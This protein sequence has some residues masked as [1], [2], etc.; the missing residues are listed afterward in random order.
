MPKTLLSFACVLGA[1][2]VMAL[3]WQIPSQLEEATDTV[4]AWTVT[5]VLACGCILLISTVIFL[6]RR[7]QKLVQTLLE[8]KELHSDSALLM[9]EAV[10]R[11]LNGFEG[12]NRELTLKMAAMEKVIEGC[13]GHSSGGPTS[14]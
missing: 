2:G 3:A 7:N 6:F 4:A 5:Q 1:A 10:T 14:G 13:R 11:M 12:L 8:D 9:Q